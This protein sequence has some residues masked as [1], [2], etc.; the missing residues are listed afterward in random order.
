[1]SEIRTVI[2]LAAGDGKRMRSA[3]PKVLHALLGRTLLGHVLCAAEPLEAQHTIVVVG[4][5]AGQVSEHLAEIAPKAQTVL[6]REPKG[7]GHATRIALDAVPESRSGTV[8]V[9]CGDT[10]LLRGQT[11]EALIAVHERSDA[12]ATVLSAAVADP[13]G[14]GRL[15]RDEHGGLS[16]IVEHRDATPEQLRINEINAGMYAFDL[17]SLRDALYR[18]SSHNAQGEEYLTDVFELLVKDGKR[19]GAYTVSDPDEALGVN[20]R[21]QLATC[22]AIMRDRVNRDWMRSGV[23]LI[24]PA[25]TWVDVTVTIGRDALIEPNTQLRGA[26]SVGEGASVGPDTTLVDVYVGDGA[27]VVRTHGIGAHIGPQ[28]SVGPFSYLRPGTHLGADGKIGA[29]VETKNA[30]IGK[31]SKVPHLSY[32]GDATIGEQANI[33][34][35]T[36]FVNYDGVEKH[37]SVVGDAAFIGCDTSLIAPVNV[38]DGAYVAAG[39]AI[40]NDV[41]PGALGVARTPQRNV[42]GWVHRRRAGTKSATAAQAAAERAVEQAG[43]GEGEG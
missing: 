26:S 27:S 24:D 17:A 18:L 1:M 37:H 21:A 31:G 41:P 13:T 19:V 22:G 3:T 9:L 10:P 33:G 43:D 35:G 2:V 32:V 42:D 8:V 29:F 5:G 4:R 16:A 30:Q 40:I 38:G 15:I 14:L 20:D 23:T 36:I 34:A 25:T 28:A 7:T 11:L 39:S 6:Q 12:K